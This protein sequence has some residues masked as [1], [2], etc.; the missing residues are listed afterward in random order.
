M[1]RVTFRSQARYLVQC[2]LCGEL[3][4]SDE[5]HAHEL[6]WRSDLALVAGA[7]VG[8]VLGFMLLCLLLAMGPA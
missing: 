4:P 2:D 6:D 7:A 3:R 5:R 8:L 1:T